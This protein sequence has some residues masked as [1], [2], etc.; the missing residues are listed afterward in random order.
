[1]RCRKVTLWIRRSCPRTGESCVDPIFCASTSG[2]YLSSIQRQL[3]KKSVDHN[4]SKRDLTT[5]PRRIGSVPL[6]N[7]LLQPI[8]QLSCH[9]SAIAYCFQRLHPNAFATLFNLFDV[10][11]TFR[12]N[13]SL[14][15]VQNA[16]QPL[17][18]N[19]II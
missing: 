12:T 10:E 17:N 11:S 3:G 8:T 1:M 6:N 18:P 5:G 14:P 13:S 7:I 15:K 2:L 9:R 19:I 16:V 4:S